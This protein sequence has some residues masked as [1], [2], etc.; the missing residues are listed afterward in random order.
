M[1]I[2]TDVLPNVSCRID[3]GWIRARSGGVHLQVLEHSSQVQLKVALV[4]PAVVNSAR[5]RPSETLSPA[6]A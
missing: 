1:A 6:G 3:D 2:S 4:G 5:R